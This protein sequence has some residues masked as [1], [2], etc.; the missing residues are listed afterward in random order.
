MLLKVVAYGPFG[1]ISDGFN[2]F[3]GF[4]VVLRLVSSIILFLLCMQFLHSS[5]KHFIPLFLFRIFVFLCKN[6]SEIMCLFLIFSI[7][8]IITN[9]FFIFN[10]VNKD[11]YFKNSGFIKLKVYEFSQQRL[12]PDILQVIKIKYNK[13]CQFLLCNTVIYH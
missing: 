5:R 4:I 3:D 13:L 10:E 2:L 6:A 7:F 8:F 9:F 1:Y 11:P 12:Q